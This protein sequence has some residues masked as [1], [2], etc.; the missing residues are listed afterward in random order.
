MHIFM[1]LLPV[2]LALLPKMYVYSFL[3]ISPK[4]F[5]QLT[6]NFACKLTVE[7]YMCLYIFKF[8][9]GIFLTILTKMLFRPISMVL[10]VSALIPLIFVK[11]TCKLVVRYIFWLRLGF[12]SFFFNIGIFCQYCQ[13]FILV[14]FFL[15]SNLPDYLTIWLENCHISTWCCCACLCILSSLYLVYFW[16]YW[17][18]CLALHIFSL[19][20][21]HS[22][23]TAPRDTISCMYFLFS[24]KSDIR[25]MNWTTVAIRGH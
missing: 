11:L 3:L 12:F 9:L 21:H 19:V 10:F 7:L 22:S 1:P 4:W 20:F 2:F 15:L 23:V 18:K 8:V 25:Y 17:T 14:I 16:Q 5:H 13:K 24:S 6:Y